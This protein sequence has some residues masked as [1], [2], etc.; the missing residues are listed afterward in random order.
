[1]DISGQIA[2]V[3]G[4]GSGLGAA[5]ARHLAG[6]GARVAILDFDILRAQAVADEIGGIAVQADVSDEAAVGAAFD[7]TTAHFGAAPRIAVS[8]AGVGLAARIVGREG[9]LSFDVFE[10][11]L[12][13]N[14]FG[15]Y[16]VMSHAARRMAEQEPMEDGERGVV[17]NTASVAFEDGQL[18]Q[19][20]YAASKGAIAA[21]CLPAARE[22]A[23][24]GIR[25][26][27]IAPGLFLTPMMES[28]P[29]DVTAKITANIPFPARLG[30]PAEFALLADQ[31]IRNRFLNGTT[32]R[33]DGAVRLPPR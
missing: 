30:A 8:C 31:I 25:V 12:K 6:Q 32:I 19:A 16:N 17:I 21:M 26:M 22:L 29:E 18:G 10:K 9:K 1:M 24:S 7:T 4:G 11:T 2:L 27:A 15:T 28:L 20:A 33:L 3:T 23:Q 14:L 5:T 13:V